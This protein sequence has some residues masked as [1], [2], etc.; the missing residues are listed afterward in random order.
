MFTTATFYGKQ[1]ETRAAVPATAI[2][3]IH[4]R[5]WV[6][7]P[8]GNGSFKRLEVTGGGML[9]GKMQEIL[10]GIKSGDQVVENALA[11]QNTVEQ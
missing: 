5:D 4:D 9:P 11:M 3:H 10:A 7:A 1:A 6:F 8:L 2:L